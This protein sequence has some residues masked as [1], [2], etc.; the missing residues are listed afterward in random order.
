LACDMG[1]TITKAQTMKRISLFLGFCLIPC[2]LAAQDPCGEN[3]RKG[4]RKNDRFTAPC[5]SMVVFSKQGFEAINFRLVKLQR[6]VALHEKGM[7]SLNKSLALRDSLAQV[8]QKEIKDFE[9]YLQDTA[10]PIA[11]LQ[12]N[13]EKSIENTDRV[14]KIAHRNKI[15]G[16]VVGALAGG[17]VGVLVGSTVF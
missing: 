11:R 15:L 7:E 13:L 2:L 12:L 6:E 17:L 16:V 10:G 3:F 9:N 8:Y 5:D 1:N 4:L 14:I